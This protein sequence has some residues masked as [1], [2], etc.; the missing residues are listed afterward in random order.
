MR[1]VL[2]VYPTT[3][4]PR[5]LVWA[6]FFGVVALA[7]LTGCPGSTPEPEVAS[8]EPEPTVKPKKARPKCEALEEKCKATADTQAKIANVDAVFIPPEGWV[9]A[10]QSEMTVA[11]PDSKA[12]DGVN[13]IIGITAFEAAGPAEAKAREAEYLK[14]L[15]GLKIAAPEKFKK[16][17]VPRWDKADDT[18]KSGSTE[19]KL[20]QAEQ[21]KRDGKN[22]FLLVLL[23]AD[24][25]GKKILGVAFSPE[26]DDKTVEA[27]SKSLE[28]IGP[29]SYQ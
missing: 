8:A 25:A 16:K 26:G 4:P 24:P 28:T 27:I 11:Q 3:M 19:I 29:G 1:E 21:A 6:G 9:F 17:Y 7:T 5:S 14:L 15:E 2:K 22:G 12:A 10:Q 18:R 23:M 13:G 20:W